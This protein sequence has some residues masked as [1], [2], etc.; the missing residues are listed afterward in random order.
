MSNSDFNVFR[1]KRDIQDVMGS[2]HH[3]IRA[4]EIVGDA[5]SKMVEEGIDHATISSV[6]FH[7][8]FQITWEF[9]ELEDWWHYAS[10]VER[11]AK[12]KKTIIE[13]I[14]QERNL[15]PPPKDTDRDGY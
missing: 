8:S 2:Q 6:L 9:S 11:S 5:C 12:G 10:F 14:Y 3:Q 1:F 4:V 13:D 7:S 15:G